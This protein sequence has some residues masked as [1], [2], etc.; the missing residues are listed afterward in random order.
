MAFQMVPYKLLIKKRGI[1]PLDLI[2]GGS[3][4]KD[5]ELSQTLTV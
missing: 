2:R 3:A 4:F 1:V 5:I